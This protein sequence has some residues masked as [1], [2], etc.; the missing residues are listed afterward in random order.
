M[1]KRVRSAVFRKR[2]LEAMERKRFSRSRLARETAVDRSTIGQ[3][4]KEDFARLP[5]AQLAADAASALEIGRAH[6]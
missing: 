4:L 6:V 3:L 1:D 5:N 2:L